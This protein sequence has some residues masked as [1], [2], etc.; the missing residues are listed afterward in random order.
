MT[1]TTYA[2]SHT[3]VA[4]ETEVGPIFLVAPDWATL[5]R[6]DTR[7]HVAFPASGA[8]LLLD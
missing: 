8:I 7:V 1:K 2:G 5:P 6:P 3:E 4:V